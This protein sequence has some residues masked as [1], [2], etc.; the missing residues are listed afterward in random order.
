MLHNHGHQASVLLGP[1]PSHPR[2]SS[3]CNE[4]A[5]KRWRCQP[6]A[7]TVYCYDVVRLQ[8]GILQRFAGGPTA[9]SHCVGAWAASMRLALTARV[10]GRE[11]A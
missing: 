2:M 6:E 3:A 9:S 4:L 1:R 7:V 5:A 8:S 11:R 10:R